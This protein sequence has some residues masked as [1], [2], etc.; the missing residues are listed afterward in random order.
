MTEPFGIIMEYT[1]CGLD[2]D[3]DGLK[4]PEKR[5]ENPLDMFMVKWDPFVKDKLKELSPDV[6]L[7]DYFSAPGIVNA[8]ESNIP[9]VINVPISLKYFE[10]LGYDMINM[11]NACSCCGLICVKRTCIRALVGCIVNKMAP[12]SKRA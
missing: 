3:R 4:K 2:V 8:N 12:Y 7:S 5:G 11:R 10:K 1:D 9:L 6:V